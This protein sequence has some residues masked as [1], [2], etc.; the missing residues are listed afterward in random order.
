MIGNERIST[1]GMINSCARCT[2]RM[3]R[4]GFLRNVTICRTGLHSFRSQLV[5]NEHLAAFGEILETYAPT[6][7]SKGHKRAWAKL[8]L[9]ALVQSDILR[10][11]AP[12]RVNPSQRGRTVKRLRR[13]TTPCARPDGN[14][15]TECQKS[16]HSN[17]DEF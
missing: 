11:L 3:L 4:F 7:G 10:L 9:P 5:E 2:K 13:K 17:V 16:F 1:S 14:C 12:F 15:L 8:K 6:R